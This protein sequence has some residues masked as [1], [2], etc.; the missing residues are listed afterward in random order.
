MGSS[1]AILTAVVAACALVGLLF[2]IA[3]ARRLHR[4]RFGACAFHGVS[5]L[6]FFLAA[7]VAGLLGFD[8]LTY[9][10]LTHEQSALRATFARSAEQQF[11]AT[12]TY[13]SGESRGYVLRG[14]EWQIDA[15]VLKWRGIANVLQFD[16]V[17]RLER[18]SG[19][20]SDV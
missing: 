14:D 6:A 7:A 15:R 1:S 20:Y 18:L 4:R 17:Y 5:S 12:L 11:N 10:R 13:P 16:T 8:L 9:D 2:L 3:C 19:R